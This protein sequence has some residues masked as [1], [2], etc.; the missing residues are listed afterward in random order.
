MA[1]LERLSALITLDLWQRV[2][3]MNRAAVAG[4]GTMLN[5]AHLICGIRT[6]HAA[7]QCHAA[8]PLLPALSRP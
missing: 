4:W 6:L 5:V 2:D 3:G 8:L 1:G 7:G